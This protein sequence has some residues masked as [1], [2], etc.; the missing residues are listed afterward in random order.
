MN[1]GNGFLAELGEKL[2]CTIIYRGK[3]TKLKVGEEEVELI[4]ALSQGAAG[5]SCKA[6]SRTSE[7]QEAPPNVLTVQAN[8]AIL[9]PRQIQAPDRNVDP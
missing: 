2:P 3:A 1:L 8:S 9:E 5:Q 4:R 7:G 6:G